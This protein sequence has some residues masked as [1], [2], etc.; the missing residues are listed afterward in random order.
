MSVFEKATKKQLRFATN[1]GLLTTEQLWQLQLRDLDALGMAIKKEIKE[2]SEE[3]LL[4]TAKKVNPTEQL[5]LDVIVRIIE[6]K[7]KDAEAKAKRVER[8]A[9][10]QQLEQLAA[11]KE[12]EKFNEQSLD[13]IKKQ[14]AEL[15]EEED[16][17]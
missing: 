15:Q 9:K 10:L 6:V 17:D 14:I 11:T 7:Q 13:E 4:S 12:N 2:S 5:K 1:R 3:T 16:E 8:A